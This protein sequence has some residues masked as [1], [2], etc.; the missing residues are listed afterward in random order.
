MS[1][2]HVG[3]VSD[4][5]WQLTF[6]LFLCAEPSAAEE[7]STPP[8]SPPTTIPTTLP[9]TPPTSPSTAPPTSPPTTLSTHQPFLP[10]QRVDLHLLPDDQEPSENEDMERALDSDPQNLLTEAVRL[11]QIDNVQALEEKLRLAES[12]LKEKEEEV[13][14]MKVEM[15]GTKQAHASELAETLSAHTTV[16]KYPSEIKK[17]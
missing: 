6:L 3:T 16:L 5:M 1:Q 7:V 17:Y 2:S 9:T 8:T 4:K 11:L 15:E 14:K 12:S 13:H 10:T